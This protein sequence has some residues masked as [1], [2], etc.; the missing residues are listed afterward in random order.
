MRD[1]GNKLDP[2]SFREINLRIYQGLPLPHVFFQPRFEPW[3]DW[4]RRFN[5]QS[6]L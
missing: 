3:Y 5:Q 1:E 6:S 2:E 4:H